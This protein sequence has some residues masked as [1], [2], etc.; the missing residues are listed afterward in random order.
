MSTFEPQNP[1]GNDWSWLPARPVS[2]ATTHCLV[3]PVQPQHVSRQVNSRPNASR[4]RQLSH[5]TSPQP[6]GATS[7]Y[8]RSVI[9]GPTDK[10]SKP[11]APSIGVPDFTASRSNTAPRTPPPA[12]SQP[13]P[14]SPSRGT[15]RRRI[16]HRRLARHVHAQPPGHRPMTRRRDPEPPLSLTA[17]ICSPTRSRPPSSQAS[18]EI[19]CWPSMVTS[20]LHLR[21]VLHDVHTTGTTHPTS[22]SKSP[23]HCTGRHRDSSCH[24]RIRGIPVGSRISV[25]ASRSGRGREPLRPCS[26][27]P[28]S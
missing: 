5:E 14:A 22:L 17:G 16:A 26:G 10:L 7:T 23:N 8:G 2:G 24:P 4:K 6:I 1:Y 27:L 21:P 25:V 3:P 19:A 20:R 28:T 11:S 13:R 18:P 12:A 9:H 15:P